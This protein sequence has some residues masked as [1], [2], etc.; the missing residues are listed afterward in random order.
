MSEKTT[1][2]MNLADMSLDELVQLQQ[3]LG[4]ELQALREKRIYLN[5][6]IAERLQRGERNGQP[7]T[8][9]RPADITA[10]EATAPGAVIAVKRS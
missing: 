9:Q 6:K 10:R 8:W 1:V 5:A 7:S 3:G 4:H 2:S